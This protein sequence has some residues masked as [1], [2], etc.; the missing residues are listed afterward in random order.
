MEFEL[1]TLSSKGQVVIPANLREGFKEGERL[2]VIRNG[3]QIVL[4]KANVLDKQ[5]EEDLK[6]AKRTEEA[7]RRHEA[8]DF[9]TMPAEDFLKEMKKWQM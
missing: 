7:Y 2:V 9:V 1:V 3:K 6:F 8:G 5:L 4:E